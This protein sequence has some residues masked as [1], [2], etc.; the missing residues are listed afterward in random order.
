MADRPAAGAVLS[1]P[2]RAG[3]ALTPVGGLEE[4]A[5]VARHR[6]DGDVAAR[7]ELVRRY[8]P[9]ARRLA[10]RFRY[11]G[12]SADDLLQVA[13]LALVKAIDRYDP[14]RGTSLYSYAVPTIVG[15]LKHHLRYAWSLH[16]PRG[17][18]ERAIEVTKAARALSAR[19]GRSP[20]PAELAEAAGMTVEQ[21]VEAIEAAGAYDALSLDVPRDEDDEAGGTYA[22]TIGDEDERFELIEYGA[23]LAPAFA[24]LPE[25]ERLVIQLRFA[26]DLTQ[27]E[28]A[29]RIGVSQ[30]HVSRLIRRAIARMSAEVNREG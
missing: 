5:L 30:M 25:R 4:R 20:K 2:L 8:M 21:V 7:E 19:M 10:G 16:V 12:E 14:E 17:T 28:I 11:T 22:E 1:V 6:D 27:T 13:C 15:E 3:A 29:E 23:T 9:L 24:S 18:Q 26:E